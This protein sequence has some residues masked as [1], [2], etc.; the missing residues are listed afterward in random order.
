M[1]PNVVFFHEN[2]PAYRTMNKAL[3]RLTENDVLLVMGTSGQVIDIG[4]YAAMT[5]VFAI[6]SNLKSETRASMPGSPVIEDRQST[7]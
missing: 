2:A 1:K 5:K 6:L 3:M 4:S 7:S